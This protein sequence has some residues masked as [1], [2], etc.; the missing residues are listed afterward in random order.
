M[1]NILCKIQKLFQLL[2]QAG[3][4]SYEFA[5]SEKHDFFIYVIILP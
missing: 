4:I 3:K 1:V 2:D 5:Q